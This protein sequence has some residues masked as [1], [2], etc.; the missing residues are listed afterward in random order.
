MSCDPLS[1]NL[2]DIDH[3]SFS[4]VLLHQRTVSIL[5]GELVTVKFRKS[6]REIFRRIF[7]MGGSMSRPFLLNYRFPNCYLQTPSDLQAATSAAWKSATLVGSATNTP[8]AVA[9]LLSQDGLPTTSCVRLPTTLSLAQSF[10]AFC[11]YSL[12]RL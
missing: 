4:A 9:T 6:W 7:K 12:N 8:K 3:L 10:A 5:V 11:E 1:T 2:R